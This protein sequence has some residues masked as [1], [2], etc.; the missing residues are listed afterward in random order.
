MVEG[1]TQLNAP[2]FTTSAS[3]FSYGSV[4]INTLKPVEKPLIDLFLFYC[5][6]LSHVCLQSTVDKL[7]KKTNLALVVGSSSWREQ[8]VSAVTV[9][10]G[11]WRCNEMSHLFI[12]WWPDLWKIE[13]AAG[14]GPPAASHRPH[15]QAVF[16]LDPSLMKSQMLMFDIGWIFKKPNLTNNKWK[17]LQKTKQGL[18]YFWQF[19]AY[20]LSPLIP[21]SLLKMH[22]VVNCLC[23]SS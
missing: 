1:V 18:I 17:G 22:D 7:I 3:L 19:C 10:A 12:P 21:E 8:F 5:F 23:D 20:L 11:E 16:F 14:S 4:K 2:L 9:S 6:F 13:P 15:C